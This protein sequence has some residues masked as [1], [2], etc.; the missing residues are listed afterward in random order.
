[1]DPEMLQQLLQA[2]QGG[3]QIR[4]YSAGGAG[5]ANSN[6]AQP[7]DV[8]GQWL[9][10]PP[11]NQGYGAMLPFLS[12]LYGQS[13]MSQPQ[14]APMMPQAPSMIPGQAMGPQPTPQ[15]SQWS[16]Q[17]PAPMAPPLPFSPIRNEG[18]QQAPVA[19]MPVTNQYTAQNQTRGMSGGYGGTP[20]RPM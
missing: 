5:W 19:T 15:V 12:A 20:F 4:P 7:Y 11:V 9:Q 14:P 8:G 18:Y 13:Q 6:T 1:M 2:F 10:G 17:G 16:S 3:Q